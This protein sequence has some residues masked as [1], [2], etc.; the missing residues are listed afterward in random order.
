MGGNGMS[1]A[2]GD[3]R[4]ATG[5]GLV[6]YAFGQE[7]QDGYAGAGAG[8]ARG[9]EGVRRWISGLFPA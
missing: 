8:I 7:M 4:Q 2:A 6:Y 9:F 1:E 3:P 5:V